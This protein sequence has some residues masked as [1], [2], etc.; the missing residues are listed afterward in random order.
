MSTRR[1]RGVRRESA[2]A[3]DAERP[4]AVGAAGLLEPL[5]NRRAGERIA[6]RLVTAIALGQY[7]AGQR[8]PSERDLAALLEVSRASVRDGLHLLAA[9]G[10]V[11]IRRGR[12][13]GAFVTNKPSTAAA[14]MIRR[15]L[16]PGWTR[17][18]QLLD[19]RGTVE[20]QIARMA[21]AR[22]TSEEAAEIARLVEMYLASSTERG[23]SQAADQALHAAIAHAAH[24]R[25]WSELS[26][27]LRYQVTQGLGA[28][29]FSAELRRRGE[30]QHP[31]LA[32]AVI[33]GDVDRAGALA[34]EHFALTSDAIERLLVSVTREQGEQVGGV[35]PG[36][37]RKG[38][39]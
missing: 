38:A 14:A 18:A 15:T 34:A 19:F 5:T 6:E 13:G 7:V 28:E 23:E 26:T 24:N 4:L 3:L 11:E 37:R 33:A 31:V 20:E 2:I 36:T 30:E 32:Q 12:S 22:R 8:L 29:P 1:G 27:Q 21:A 9:E 25:F 16:L 39:R 10:H 35:P 17:L